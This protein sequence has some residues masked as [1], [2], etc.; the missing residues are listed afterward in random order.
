[1]YVCICKAVTDKQIRQSVK[2]GVASYAELQKALSVGLQCGK[3]CHEAQD[4]I[5]ETIV[6]S[7]SS[8]RPVAAATLKL[9][10]A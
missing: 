10:R 8:R 1:M 3:C 6:E 9:I 2:E 5:E 7:A 4:I